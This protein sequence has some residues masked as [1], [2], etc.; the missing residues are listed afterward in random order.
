MR[1]WRSEDI[2]DSADKPG[3]E[4]AYRYPDVHRRMLFQPGA[5][6]LMEFTAPDHHGE[7]ASNNKEEPRT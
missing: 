2:E 6:M 3:G 5:R 7:G 1:E 4:F